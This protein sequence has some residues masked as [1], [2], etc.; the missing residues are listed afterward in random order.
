MP[1]AWASSSSDAAQTCVGR[2]W[3]TDPTM[4]LSRSQ[5]SPWLRAH[6]STSESSPS[7]S[8]KPLSRSAR[9]GLPKKTRNGQTPVPAA[10]PES[11]VAQ[12]LR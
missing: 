6:R 11:S 7:M 4:R 8:A 5:W 12:T 3:A 9:E 2:L 1:V 10:L